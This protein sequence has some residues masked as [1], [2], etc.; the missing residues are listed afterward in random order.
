MLWHFAVRTNDLDRTLEAVAQGGYEVT[1]SAKRVDLLDAVRDQAFSIR[2][3]FFR[4][5][6]GEEI[7]LF[8]DRRGHT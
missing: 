2:I 7:E 3:A 5:P 6:D 8:E 1:R 4:G